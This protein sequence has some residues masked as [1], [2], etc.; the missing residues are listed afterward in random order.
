MST[1]DK[2]IA[3]ECEGEKHEGENETSPTVY[4]EKLRK[5]LK[6]KYKNMPIEK[7][8]KKLEKLL[9]KLE[10]LY[11]KERKQNV[12]LVFEDV[13]R[14]IR[15]LLE[16]S[17]INKFL[18]LDLTDDMCRLLLCAT[19][20]HTYEDENRDYKGKL[21][22]TITANNGNYCKKLLFIYNDIFS[23]TESTS[24]LEEESCVIFT[25]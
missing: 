20:H 15:N 13:G 23:K 6:T 17:Y 5:Q 21:F 18:R 14:K 12:D 11:K 8:I 25:H 4:L 16:Q 22:K 19:G 2:E 10:K 24:G 1:A 7:R 3:K 9:T